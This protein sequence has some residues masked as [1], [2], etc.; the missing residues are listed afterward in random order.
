M[1]MARQIITADTPTNTEFQTAVMRSGLPSARV[2]QSKV[3]SSSG[4][5]VMGFELKLNTIRVAIG[6]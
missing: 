6:V 1:P 4:R 2:Y 5:R 3:K